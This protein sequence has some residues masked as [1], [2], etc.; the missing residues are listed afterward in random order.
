MLQYTLAKKCL[1]HSLQWRSHSIPL[2]Q[3][4]LS[5]LWPPHPTFASTRTRTHST[6]HTAHSTQHILSYCVQLLAGLRNC[7]YVGTTQQ[8]PIGRRKTVVCWFRHKSSIIKNH[9]KN[10]R[11]TERQ[12]MFQSAPRRLLRYAY[13]SDV[14]L[15]RGCGS[16]FPGPKIPI[17]IPINSPR[18][19]A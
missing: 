5:D 12:N 1:A 17:P 11:M 2:I 18:F 16:M 8:Y 3:A 7:S 13:H 19:I 4:E 6:Q 14:A 10:D 9:L 15:L